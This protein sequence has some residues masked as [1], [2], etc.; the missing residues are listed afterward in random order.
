[1]GSEERRI[2]VDR[3]LE[4]IEGTD[5]LLAMHRQATN[6]S[7]SMIDQYLGIKERLVT[8]LAELLAEYGVKVIGT[9][10]HNRHSA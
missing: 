3:L 6:P 1:M 9:A 7:Q 2:R 8:E 5:E 10:A 4:L